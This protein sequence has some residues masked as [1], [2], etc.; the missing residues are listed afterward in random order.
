MPLAWHTTNT[1]ILWGFVASTFSS[2]MSGLFTVATTN[3]LMLSTAR[4]NSPTLE[5]EIKQTF[6]NPKFAYKMQYAHMRQRWSFLPVYY[7]IAHIFR[8]RYIA[9]RVTK[10]YIRSCGIQVRFWNSAIH[11]LQTIVLT[12]GQQMRSYSNNLLQNDTQD[13][14]P[15]N[16]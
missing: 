8:T 16:D 14:T 2:I 11:D 1:K 15:K 9:W 12:S 5:V 10:L 6:S 4:A 13:R 7:E 3:K